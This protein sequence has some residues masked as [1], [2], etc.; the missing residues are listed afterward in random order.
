MNTQERAPLIRC[1]GPPANKRPERTRPERTE[2]EDRDL[3]VR[4]RNI[5]T[6]LEKSTRPDVD[7]GLAER[8][9]RRDE[10]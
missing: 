3:A 5:H 6:P 1:L 2:H 9:R 8:H 7:R 4:A 10:P